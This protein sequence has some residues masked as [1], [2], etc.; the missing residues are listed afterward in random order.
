MNF[1]MKKVIRLTESELHNIIT[2]AAKK[3][4]REASGY[5]PRDGMTGGAWSYEHDSAQ[6]DID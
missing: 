6:I 5:I 2:S 4:I 3:I 1:H